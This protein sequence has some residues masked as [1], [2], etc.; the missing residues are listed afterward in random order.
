MIPE[1]KPPFLGNWR[2]VYLLLAGA[3]A[4]TIFFLGFITHYFQ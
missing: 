2:N 4:L 3:L 1:E